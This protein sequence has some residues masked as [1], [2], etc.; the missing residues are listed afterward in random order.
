MPFKTSIILCTYNEAK[1]IEDT[2][3][4]LE[5]N[6]LKKKEIRMAAKRAARVSNKVTNKLKVENSS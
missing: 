1:Y 2:I 5:K 4:E 3:V 6:Y